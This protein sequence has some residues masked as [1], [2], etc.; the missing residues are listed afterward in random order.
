MQRAEFIAYPDLI[1]VRPTH[2]GKLYM[3]QNTAAIIRM[4]KTITRKMCAINL[5]FVILNACT[6]I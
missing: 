1:V 2:V 4:K 6:V 5:S 3:V